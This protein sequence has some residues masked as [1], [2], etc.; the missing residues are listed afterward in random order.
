MEEFKAAKK[1]FVQGRQALP[2][3][4][5][6]KQAAAS[7][8]FFRGRKV[9]GPMMI[10]SPQ[11]CSYSG[12]DGGMFESSDHIACGAARSQGQECLQHQ[13][14]CACLWRVRQPLSGRM[15]LEFPGQS[16]FVARPWSKTLA[17]G[18]SV[19]DW[20]GSWVSDTCD[21]CDRGLHE[22]E[23]VASRSATHVGVYFRRR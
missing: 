19:G 3:V 15:R 11:V 2:V 6:G 18:K 10:F 17:G 7:N 23:P 4:S 20:A 14:T 8:T 22:Y 1:A 9:K 21:E 5:E 12:C 13:G 16:S